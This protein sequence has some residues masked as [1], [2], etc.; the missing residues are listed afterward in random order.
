[1]SPKVRRHS[2]QSA[3][4]DSSSMEGTMTPGGEED[5]QFDAFLEMKASI[6]EC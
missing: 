4:D 1:M 5:Y 6:F 2:H 3:D